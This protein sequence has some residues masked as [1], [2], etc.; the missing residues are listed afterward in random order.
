MATVNVTVRLGEFVVYADESAALG[1]EVTVVS[2]SVGVNRADGST[3]E[4]DAELDIGDK[5][6]MMDPASRI[7][8][9][10]IKIEKDATVYNPAYNEIDIDKKGTSVLGK[11]T[12]PLA[13]PVQ[14]L[15]AL[16]ADFTPGT[17][18]LE[19]KKDDPSS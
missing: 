12:T 16:P 5:V 4:K 6:Q 13:V 2:G 18:K 7:V 9:D 1:K 17:E 14:N 3:F 15:P 8:A 19:V 10:S 11:S